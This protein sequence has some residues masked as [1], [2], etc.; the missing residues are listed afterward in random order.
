M[1]LYATDV[2]E[3]VKEVHLLFFFNGMR[4]DFLHK[5]IVV[6]DFVILNIL[7]YGYVKYDMSH[8]HYMMDNSPM[9]L[10]LMANLAMI[11][12]QRLF[13]NIITVRKVPS[14]L[15]LRQVVMLVLTQFVMTFAITKTIFL[16]DHL[17]AP[18]VPFT[19][20]FAV[21]MAV[22][23]VPLRFLELYIVKQLRKAG[24]FQ[25]KVL[26]VGSDLSL[27]E[28]C[29][30]ISSAVDGYHIVGWY[31]NMK[32]D[33]A[34]NILGSEN[35]FFQKSTIPN[36]LAVDHVDEVYCSFPIAMVS[37]INQ[38]RKYC[39]QNVAHF[40]YVPV[41]G[42][43]I[44]R[45]LKSESIGQSTAF[46][47]YV[48]PLSLIENRLIKRGF[49]IL[50]SF[51]ILVLLLPFIPVVAIVIRAQSRGPLFFTQ[52]R[53]G[54]NGKEFTCFK[55]RSMHVNAQSDVLQAREDD[56]RKFPFG[57]FMRKLNIDELPQ[58]WNVLVGNMSVVG[59]RPHMLYHTEVYA[60]LIEKYMVRH[61][62]KPGI[63]GWAQVSGFRGETK[64]LWQM[65]GRI[66]RDIW[67]MEHWSIWLDIRIVWLTL[68]QLVIRNEHAY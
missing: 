61:F 40:H 38:V 3:A 37:K 25:R 17:K 13:S 44:L 20:R 39:D 32:L 10:C 64:E 35:D 46:T 19:V 9:M 27:E 48:Y 60:K 58:F 34:F 45:T 29:K 31:T 43:E 21:V 8:H 28:I 51:V 22:V 68:K 47:D 55:F 36:Y 62:V 30:S 59:P 11:V 24:R 41:K 49:D 53:T 65:E 54:L 63:T 23:Y 57:S 14:E 50:F 18:A 52:R 56:P 5:I 66:K 6:L 42:E 7:F 33:G 67:Y 2:T 15:V 1:V 26:L 16:F 4:S 12:A